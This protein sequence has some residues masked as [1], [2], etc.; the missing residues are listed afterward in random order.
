MPSASK[1][2]QRAAWVDSADTI[3][4]GHYLT[5]FRTYPQRRL[6]DAQAMALTNSM[7]S[8][9]PFLSVSRRLNRAVDSCCC[10]LKRGEWTRRSD[11]SASDWGVIALEGKTRGFDV[12]ISLHEVFAVYRVQQ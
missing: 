3:F 4:G 9:K 11:V 10:V 2:K 6:P 7:A 5:R 1:Q 12:C 8:I